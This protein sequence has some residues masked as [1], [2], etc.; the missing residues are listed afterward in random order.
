[1]VTREYAL[2]PEKTGKKST[3]LINLDVNLFPSLK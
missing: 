1:M 3:I 2:I